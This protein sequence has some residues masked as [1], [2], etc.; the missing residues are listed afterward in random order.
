[1]FDIRRDR[2]ARIK[3]SLRDV[4]TY[5]LAIEVKLSENRVIRY[6]YR[7]FRV[8][9]IR[10]LLTYLE[11]NPVER[12]HVQPDRE[13]STNRDADTDKRTNVSLSTIITQ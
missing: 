2:I 7:V 9:Q 12:E 3:N 11:T 4:S 6:P 5:R 1:M 13:T 8:L 10:Y